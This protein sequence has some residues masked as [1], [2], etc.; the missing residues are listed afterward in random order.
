M[1]V[2]FKE[3]VAT[4]SPPTNRGTTFLTGTNGSSSDEIST[5][6]VEIIPRR[7]LRNKRG[8]GFEAS[9]M[10]SSR[11]TYLAPTARHGGRRTLS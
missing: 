9:P 4:V 1:K 3:L 5:A 6:R 7:Y 11:R 10:R 8:P 2:G